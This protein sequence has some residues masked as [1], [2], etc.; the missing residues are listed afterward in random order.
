MRGDV[1]AR[2]VPDTSNHRIPTLRDVQSSSSSSSHM[3]VLVASHDSFEAGIR[4]FLA[5]DVEALE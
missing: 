2:M 4:A 1:Y 5:C 3:R